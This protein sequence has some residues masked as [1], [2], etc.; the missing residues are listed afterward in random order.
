MGLGRKK[1]SSRKAAEKTPPVG[2]QSVETFVVAEPEPEPEPV[3]E[4]TRVFISKKAGAVSCLVGIITADE[5]RRRGG[6]LPQ[7]FPGGVKAVE[8]MLAA[9]R[10]T[11]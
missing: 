2:G 5:S 6:L 1:K 11:R 4:K 3:N 9:G 7:D 8:T 10:L